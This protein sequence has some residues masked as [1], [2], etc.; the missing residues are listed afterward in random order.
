M[1]GTGGNAYISKLLGEQKKEKARNIF[2]LVIYTTFIGGAIIVILGQ[3]LL[4]PIASMLGAEGELLD[5]A[6][7]YGRIVLCGGIP[8]MLQMEFQSLFSTACK[9]K[10]G[11]VVT[12]VAGISNIILDALLIGVW[13]LGL[14]GAGAATTVSM[15]IG[16]IVPVLYFAVKR[17]GSLMHIICANA[18]I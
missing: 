3:I 7:L 18:C 16:G 6:V 2:S 14:V 13:K 1:L 8:F 15:T 17:D 11:L 4:R 12:V 5:N 9:P 10:L